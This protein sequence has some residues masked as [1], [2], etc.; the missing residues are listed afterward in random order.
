MLDRQLCALPDQSELRPV[1]GSRLPAVGQLALLVRDRHGRER[2]LMNRFGQ[3]TFINVFGRN[4]VIFGT[5]DAAETIALNREKNFESAGAWDHLIGSRFKRGLLLM[6][7]SEHRLHRSIM[8]QAFTNARLQGY[9]REMAGMLGDRVRSIPAGDI[10]LA[11]EF[12]SIIL[13]V[14]LKVFV[15]VTLSRHEADRI[16]QAFV[17][18]LDSLGAAVR[19]AVPGGKWARGIRGRTELE[20]FFYGLIPSKRA[21]ETPDLFSVLCHARSEEG[22]VFS[23]ED[24]VN[25]MIFLLFAAHDTSAVTISTMAFYMAKHP[26]WQVRARERA[27][28]MTALPEYSSLAEMSEL[29]LIF[30]EATRLNAPVPGVVRQ[31]R[32][33]AVIDGYL[34]PKGSIVMASTFSVHTNPRYWT[35]PETFDPTRFA[36]ERAEE[37]THRYAW[38]PFGGGVHKCIG[39]YFAQMEIKT[40]LHNLLRDYEW[41]IPDGQQWRERPG[42][43]GEPKDGLRVTIRRLRP[44]QHAAP[45]VVAK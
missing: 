7:F 30:R 12:K 40:I 22:A 25:H 10:Q 35:K 1:F 20:K 37:K 28:S 23:D 26:E 39:L 29:D 27:L 24:V 34:V 18:S 14:A 45:A 36:P 43:L 19:Y 21:T 5:A 15:G 31:V 4:L 38:M 13:D 3:A 2:R 17:D 41:S 33:D 9:L 32:E 44:A 6:D 11:A 8:Q 42:S 16:N